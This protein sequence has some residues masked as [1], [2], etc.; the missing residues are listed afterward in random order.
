MEAAHNNLILSSAQPNLRQDKE[1]LHVFGEFV[2]NFLLPSVLL[3][4]CALVIV[5]RFWPLLSGP[6]QDDDAYITYRYAQN[7]AEGK[8]LVFN[9][10]EYLNSASSFLYTVILSFGFELQLGEIPSLGLWL[11]LISTF[12]LI[13]VMCRFGMILHD[14]ALLVFALAL[15]ICISGSI[16]GWAVSGMETSLYTLLV[17]LFAY[18][19]FLKKDLAA[20]LVLGLVMLCRVEGVIVWVSALTALL[21]GS[22]PDQRIHRFRNYLLVGCITSMFY[23][24]F[25]YFFYGE[26]LPHPVRMKKLHYFYSPPFIEKVRNILSSAFFFAVLVV[27]GLIHTIRFSWRA[28]F[29]SGR[30]KALSDLSKLGRLDNQLQVTASSSNLRILDCF[31]ATFLILSGLSFLVGPIADLGRYMTHL[32]PLLFIASLRVLNQEADT[33]MGNDGIVKSRLQRCL[34]LMIC[35]VLSIGL[36]L[37]WMNQKKFSKVFGVLVE[38]QLIRQSMGEWVKA[39]IPKDEI[40]ISSNIGIISFTAKDHRFLD[41]VGLTSKLPV[42]AIEQRDW[43]ILLS[44][45]KELKPRWIVDSG[46]KVRGVVD[47]LSFIEAPQRVFRRLPPEPDRFV[48]TDQK[49]FEVIFSKEASDGNV[50][51]ILRVFPEFYESFNVL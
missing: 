5:S 37:S 49:F 23:F 31:L 4:A 24:G 41:I 2:K 10:G 25:N 11:G 29:N 40:V 12:V 39:N 22:S 45:L 8:G 43:G 35:T 21:V 27:F 51:Q 32:I 48:K 44:K 15:P 14:S 28:L 19:F 6:I 9:P 3:L 46:P 47:A 33:G 16:C 26:L 38:H 36:L 18:F 30:S 7:L 42:E 50:F 34:P 1:K 13:P 17:L 20:L